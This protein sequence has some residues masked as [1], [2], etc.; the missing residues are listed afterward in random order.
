MVVGSWPLSYIL[1]LVVTM[2]GFQLLIAGLSKAGTKEEFCGTLSG[3]GASYNMRG[4][5]G[6]QIA[7][8][9]HDTARLKDAAKDAWHA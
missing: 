8:V 1:V 2:D 3:N 4:S 5:L 7:M 9:C 6:Q